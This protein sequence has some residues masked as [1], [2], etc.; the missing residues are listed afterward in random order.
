ILRGGIVGVVGGIDPGWG[1]ELGTTP[2]TTLLF[3][4]GP[5]YAL[6]HPLA[7]VIFLGMM[8]GCGLRALGRRG[9]TWKG[10]RY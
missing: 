2:R 10:R 5:W 8:F 1:R 3:R 7:G 4:V 6:A 9:V